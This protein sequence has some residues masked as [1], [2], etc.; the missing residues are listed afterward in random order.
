MRDNGILRAPHGPV[1]F[2]PVDSSR[3]TGGKL[4]ALCSTRSNLSSGSSRPN[5]GIA[6]D[7]RRTLALIESRA[8]QRE[9]DRV[10]T[11]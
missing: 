6:R 2:R 3:I 11:Q 9:P 7:G 8:A 1:V 5:V 10:H 4:V